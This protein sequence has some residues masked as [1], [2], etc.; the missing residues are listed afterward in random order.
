MNWSHKVRH[1]MSTPAVFVEIDAKPSSV[2]ALLEASAFHHLPVLDGGVLVGVVSTLDLARVSLAAWVSDERTE[3]AWLDTQF[4]ISDLMTWE[5]RFVRADD[6]VKLAADKLSD[7]DIHC[8]PVLDNSD[9]LV[10]MITSTDLLRWIV[11][12]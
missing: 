10:G 6:S 5:P 12:A 9:A 3:R 2:L 1:L 8:L 7:G 4:R 11:T